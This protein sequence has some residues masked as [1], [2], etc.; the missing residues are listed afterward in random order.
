MT[1]VN[2]RQG[3]FKRLNK[4]KA[5]YKYYSLILIYTY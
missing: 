1:L 3:L 4:L 2:K 5:Y